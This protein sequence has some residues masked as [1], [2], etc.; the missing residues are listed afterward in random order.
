M[1]FRN[2]IGVLFAA[3]MPALVAFGQ[4][5]PPTPATCTTPPTGLTA[6]NIER[7]LPL[8][9][10]LSTFTPNAPA[11]LLAA[12]F[13]GALEIR[14]I[15]IYNPQL[16]TVTL[17]AFTVAAGSPLPTPNFDFTTGVLQV[18]TFK[19]SQILTSCSPSPSVLLVGTVTSQTPAN[20]LFG[21]YT[22]ATAALSFGYTTDNPPKINNVIGG[23]A[24]VAMA[25]SASATGTL[26][27]PPAPTT[28][29]GTPP[30]T[31]PTV[32]VNFANGTVAVPLTTTQTAVSP[33]LLDASSS[34]GNGALTFTWS[35]TSNSP[36]AF[37]STGTPGQILVQFPGPGDYAI[38]LT[39]TDS[40]GAKATFS[41]TLEYTGRP[42]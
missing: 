21:N 31:G 41:L 24:G 19:L 36:V 3:I 38:Q 40:T 37:V 32:V 29:G 20:G 25:W 6:L 27:F 13:G 7:A 8:S 11:S 42:E 17:T 9:G 16:G 26:T 35:T 39:V 22:G 33:F 12:I 14:E 34:S 4:T 30:G 2:K 1:N 23:I 5:T 28:G 15:T 18:T 10:Q